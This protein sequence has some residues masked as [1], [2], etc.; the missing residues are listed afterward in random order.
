MN[1]IADLLRRFAKWQVFW[2]VRK[3]AGRLVNG[4]K[5]LTKNRQLVAVNPFQDRS[6]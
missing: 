6:G 4:R 5:L 1:M 3:E 2:I